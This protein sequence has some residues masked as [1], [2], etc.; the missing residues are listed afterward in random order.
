M[1]DS[2]IIELYWRREESAIEASRESYGAYCYTIA[3]NILRCEQDAEECVSDTWLGAWNSIPP[4]R[5]SR[6]GLFFGRITRNLAIDRY[7]RDRARKYGSGELALCLDELGECISD[8][9]PIED[10]IALKDAMH[11]FL[12]SLPERSRCI[13]MLRYLYMTPVGGIAERCSMTEGAVKMNLL[14]TRKKLRG[15]LESEGYSV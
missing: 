7:R 9:R 12:T 3:D 10:R 1:D 6:L 15:F 4:H 5:P 2:G 11:R 14:R 8:S 13:F